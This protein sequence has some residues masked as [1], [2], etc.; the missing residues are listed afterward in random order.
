MSKE[1]TNAEELRAVQ[2][3]LK[4]LYRDHP[5]NARIPALAEGIL[6]PYDIACTVRTW[7][8]WPPRAW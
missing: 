4:Q 3:P 7:L 2:A 6:E 8:M 1:I 5:E